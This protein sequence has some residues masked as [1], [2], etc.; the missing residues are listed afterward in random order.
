MVSA[1]IDL[2][3]AGHTHLERSQPRSRGRGHYFN[4]GTWARLIRIEPA[5]RQDAA[6]FERLFRLLDGATMEALDKARVTVGATDRQI[7]LR[8]NTVVLIEANTAAALGAAVRVHA[9]LQHVLPADGDLPIRLEPADA[10][11]WTGG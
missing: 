10:A 6:A 4:S 1:D 5:V 8:R 11:T 2:L 3:V 7:V 9:S